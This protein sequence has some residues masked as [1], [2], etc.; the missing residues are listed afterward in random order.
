[1]SSTPSLSLTEGNNNA[2]LHVYV[3]FPVD[4]NHPQSITRVRILSSHV[5]Q[6]PTGPNGKDGYIFNVPR[7]L[8]VRSKGVGW[9]KELFPGITR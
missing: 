6:N 8:Q 3:A 9:I 7:Y 5:P 1:M 4:I 2:L